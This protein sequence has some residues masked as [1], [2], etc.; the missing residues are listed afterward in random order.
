MQVIGVCIVGAG[1]I[2]AVHAAHVASHPGADLR[3]VVDIDRQS[4]HALGERHGAPVVGDLSEALADPAVDAVIIAS[5]SA[6]HAEFLLASV[7]AG[8]A[9]FCEKPIDTDLARVNTRMAEIEAARVPVYMGFN[10]RF[11]PSHRAVYDAVRGGE[12]GAV[13]MIAITSRDPPEPPSEDFTASPGAL[14]RET[15]IHDLDMA[16]WLLDEE[17]VEIF[18]MASAHATSGSADGREADT[19]MVLLRTDGGSLC[20]INNSWRSCYGY[21]QRVEVFGSKGMVRSGNVRPTSV[22]RLSADGSLRDKLL[23]YFIDRYARSYAAEL[24]HFIEVVKTGIRPLTTAEDGRRALV[25][26][27][28]TLQSHRTGLPVRVVY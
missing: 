11:D 17:P 1:R 21:D 15:M 9:V 12:V 7:R 22:E 3:A 20:H 23:H 4:A 2:G 24:D 16:R 19:A 26:A 18:A 10:R 28:A 13:E 8:K 6:T 5:A 14:F 25:L 27:E